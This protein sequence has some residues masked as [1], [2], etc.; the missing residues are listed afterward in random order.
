MLRLIIIKGEVTMYEDI[1]R[2]IR[3]SNLKGSELEKDI[4]SDNLI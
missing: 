3:N 4:L 2:M 1:K